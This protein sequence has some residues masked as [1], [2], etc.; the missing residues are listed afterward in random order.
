MKKKTYFIFLITL[1]SIIS[2]SAISIS[3][4]NPTPINNQETY[5]NVNIVVNISDDSNVSAFIDFDGHL[6]RYITMDYSNTT[7]IYDNSSYNNF[8]KFNNGL[9][10][11]N[12]STGIRGNTLCFD[13]LNDKLNGT[14]VP[15]IN[16]RYNHS[17]S[18]WINKNIS[19]SSSNPTIFSN[20]N[21]SSADRFGM[22][23]F[24][25]ILPELSQNNITVGYFNGAGYTST[26]GMM[27][28]SNEWN[29]IVYN[30]YSNGTIVLFINSI[31]QVNLFGS[32]PT[33]NFNQSFNIGNRGDNI[34]GFHGC[35]DEIIVFNNTL[36]QSEINN[37]YN[38]N[39]DK[40]NKTYQ[41]LIEGQHN[42][43]IYS[44]NQ[45]GDREDSGIRTFF[46]DSFRENIFIKNR[47]LKI[48]GGHLIIKT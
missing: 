29:H 20:S 43:T 6:V 1:L 12:I 8:L 17:V 37:L 3:F 14:Y 44:V 7:G 10:V 45:L 30:Y 4:E 48:L 36:S 34:Y 19:Q 32:S 21:G 33:L 27:N 28:F 5:N 25:P 41:N 38:S 26:S 46:V 9:E 42:Y 2:I 40:F 11:N 22:Q 16:R 31:V 39:Q 47:H 35:L 23:I 24:T 15:Q 13:G 18:V